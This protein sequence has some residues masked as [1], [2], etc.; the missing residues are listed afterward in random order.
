MVTEMKINF[1]NMILLK[2]T[3]VEMSEDKSTIQIKLILVH[4]HDLK[5]KQNFIKL[6]KM[7]KINK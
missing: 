7:N 6:T 4:E 3:V 5:V 2:G 1:I